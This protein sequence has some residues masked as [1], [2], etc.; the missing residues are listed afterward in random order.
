M[1]LNRPHRLASDAVLY[2]PHMP[3][4][5]NYNN[6]VTNLDFQVTPPVRSMSVSEIMDPHDIRNAEYFRNAFKPEVLANYSPSTSAISE[7]AVYDSPTNDVEVSNTDHVS[8][9]TGTPEVNNG[10]TQSGVKPA[11]ISTTKSDTCGVK[12]RKTDPD[13]STRPETTTRHDSFGTN[14]TTGKREYLSQYQ[15]GNTDDDESQD[16]HEANDSAPLARG[17]HDTVL[18]G[19]RKSDSDSVRETDTSSDY[20]RDSETST[21]VDIY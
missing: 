7:H 15:H 9:P 10:S 4:D 5:D 16:L 19:N 6:P 13:R 1:P 11:A 14:L 8:T 18:G 2:M 21:D 3:G 17:P 20:T 12:D